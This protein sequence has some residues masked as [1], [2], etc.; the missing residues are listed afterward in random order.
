M[1]G[2]SKAF[3]YFV[4]IA[5]FAGSFLGGWIASLGRTR[6]LSDPIAPVLAERHLGWLITLTAS[7]VLFAIYFAA[8]DHPYHEMDFFHE[9][10]HLSPA[11]E[12]LAN[13]KAYGEVF[14][15]HGLGIDGG[16]DALV[17]GNPPSPRRVRLFQSV[18]DAGTIAL[19]A[20][21]AA[22]LLVTPLGFVLALVLSFC[23]LGAGQV[24]VFPYF[25]LAPLLFCLWLI[26]RYQRR[27]HRLEL[28]ASAAVAG[29]GLL[30][31]LEVGLYSLGGLVCWLVLRRVLKVEAVSGRT[32]ASVGA[33]AL[34]VPL[35]IL[36]IIRA[37]IGQFVVDSFIILPSSIDAVW[38]LPAPSLSALQAVR[39]PLK[40]ID[41]EAAR[42][43]FPPVLYGLL[44]AWGV[45]DVRAG[46]L[47]RADALMAVALFSFIAFRTAAGR[48]GWSHTRFGVPFLGIA[49][50]AYVLEP[51]I[52]RLRFRERRAFAVAALLFTSAFVFIFVEI[53]ENAMGLTR[54]LR[55]R[56]DRLQPAP[57][58]VLIPLPRAAELYTYAENASDLA[59]L[60]AF[61]RSFASGQP[62]L[63]FSGEKALYYLLARPS[64]TRVQ[65]IPMLS[66]PRLRDEALLQL[67]NN[68]P[69]YVIMKGLPHLDNF[70]GVSNERRVP[71]IVEWIKENYPNRKRVGRFDIALR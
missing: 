50:A 45:S 39:S 67:R 53:S 55:G 9:G 30:W 23:A 2:Y 5:L 62:I 19:L 3:D 26:L 56:G 13:R 18:L 31:S 20:P 63:V 34:A 32:A 51:L 41:S 12:L 64:A 15:L 61:D 21:I 42:Y 37:D 17:L 38:S 35:L 54:S 10:E 40:W 16:L 43:Y 29:A 66:A 47:R 65:D 70:D 27:G 25:R 68:P 1:A 33:T 52:A 48:S 71:E 59:A 58:S 46:R 8:H 6:S 57:G 14:F 36:L 4:V 28:L 7:G 24:A 44:L 22:E 69:A 11:S 49:L 60:A